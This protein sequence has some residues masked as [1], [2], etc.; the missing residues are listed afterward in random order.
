M[1]SAELDKKEVESFLN[2]L[3]VLSLPKDRKKVILVRTLQLLK[4]ASVKQAGSQSSP[5]GEPWKPR[6]NGTAKMLRRIASLFNSQAQDKEGK[7]FYKLKRTG[8]IAE[9]HQYGLPQEFESSQNKNGQSES[10][11]DPA[12]KRQAKKLRDLGYRRK[13]GKKAKRLSIKEIQEL[14]TIDQAGAIIRKMQ[15]N[16]EIGKGLKKW[17]IPTVK[18]PFFDEREHENA[19][20][21]T[22]VITKYLAENGI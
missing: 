5:T 9:Q 16:G 8:E 22:A 14:L 19:K 20:I 6:K 3:K 1:I 2:D 15:N 10:G 13:I 17:T 12:T 21:I 18:R 7:L 4:K 11:K